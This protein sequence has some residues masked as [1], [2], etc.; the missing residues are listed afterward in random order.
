[1]N[2]VLGLIFVVVGLGAP[3]ASAADGDQPA[4]LRHAASPLA[5]AA[6]PRRSPTIRFAGLS[7]ND[8]SVTEG[9]AGSVAAVFTVSL[10][11]ASGEQVTVDYATSD[12]TAHAPGDYQSAAGT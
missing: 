6:S 2:R 10:D 5:S 9:N 12:G 3:L 4:P 7:I 11:V 1:M 8:V